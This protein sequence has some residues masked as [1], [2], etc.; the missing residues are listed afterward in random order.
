MAT[1]AEPAV[2]LSVPLGVD[3]GTGPNWGAAH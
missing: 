3:I 1:A 2:T